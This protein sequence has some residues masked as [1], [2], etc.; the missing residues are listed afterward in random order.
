M[1]YDDRAGAVSGSRVAARDGVRIAWEEAG[2]GEPVL[3]IHGLGYDRRGWGPAPTILAER[4]RVITFD[5]RG[6][7]ESDAPPGPYTIA[8]MAADA[9]AVLAEAAVER[10]HVVG[11]SLGGMIAQELALRSPHRVGTLVLSS[12]T[13][14]GDDAF[15]MP[16]ASVELYAAFADDPSRENLQRVVENSLSAQTVATRPELVEEIVRYRLDHRPGRDAWL[17]QA[18]AGVGFSSRS[19]LAALDTPTLLIHGMDDNVVD[20]RNSELLAHALPDAELLLVPLTGHLGFWEQATYFADA[21][22]DFLG[23][24]GRHG[25]VGAGRHAG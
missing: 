13:P 3:F 14:G 4:F 20:P 15:P 17:A 24:R 16:Q 5:N 21:V 6:V 8:E 2:A 9:A 12:T 19:A 11:T 7:G 22:V 10:A 23:R 1:H 25:T 18:S